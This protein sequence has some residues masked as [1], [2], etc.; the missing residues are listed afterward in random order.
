MIVV[1]ILVKKFVTPC[2]R[3]VV[4]EQTLK[5]LGCK[6]SGREK[7]D[8]EEIGADLSASIAKKWSAFFGELLF[9]AY[10]KGHA[11]N[12]DSAVRVAT[13]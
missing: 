5:F 2:N 9:G 7:M 11:Y 4:V 13:S 6:N 10:G 12:D 8:S 3:D 1:I